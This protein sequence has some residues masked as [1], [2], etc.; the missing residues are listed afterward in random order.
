MNFK[1]KIGLS[2][3]VSLILGSSTINNA[4]EN[5]TRY[6]G[7]DRYETSLKT[8]DKV[9]SRIVVF[10]SG[11]NYA[12][13]MSAI[14]LINSFNAKLIL[15]NNKTNIESIVKDKGIEK[16]YLVGGTKMISKSVEDT[17]KNHVKNV[18]RIEGL[19]RYETNKKTLE[20]SKYKDVGVATGRNYAD[21]L[22]ASGLL[23]EKHFGLMLVDGTKEYKAPEGVTVKYT[24]GGKDTVK[25]DGG[26][27]LQGKDRYDTSINI[28]TK[29]TYKNI[30]I[31]SGE[32]FADALSSV[33]IV[34]ANKSYILL[35]E[36]RSELNKFKNKS[37]TISVV[38]GKNVLSDN[39]IND[40]I[41]TIKKTEEPSTPPSGGSGGGGIVNPGGGS[42]NK[43]EQPE[44]PEE[45][46]YDIDT[47]FK[48]DKFYNDY[49]KNINDSSIVINKDALYGRIKDGLV[50]EKNKTKEEINKILN[51]D[52]KKIYSKP[53]SARVCIVDMNRDNDL[54]GFYL[55]NLRYGEDI[56]ASNLV[57]S[58]VPEGYILCN[59]EIQIDRFFGSNRSYK[60]QDTMDIYMIPKADKIW[61]SEEEVKNTLTDN[62]NTL[63][64]KSNE[65]KKEHG[66][67]DGQFISN[68]TQYFN[69]KFVAYN[70]NMN[71]YT[72]DFDMFLADLQLKYFKSF[73]LRVNMNH[74]S[75]M[76]TEQHIF[77]I[78]V[79]PA[80]E[81]EFFMNAD[82]GSE[83]YDF[84][85]NDFTDVK[86]HNYPYQIFPS[87]Y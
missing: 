66:N 24:F 81:S 25:Q 83:Y 46:T 2:L 79:R 51:D 42:D 68:N 60:K 3:I 22:S 58:R 28:A 86:W 53:Q 62:Y 73:G 59:D 69:Y 70:K 64:D 34:N 40:M 26:E 77:T 37:E 74:Q 23:N 50:D 10:A 76:T 14:N 43:P 4:A 18:E 67:I 75:T 9:N 71:L 31:A 8:A 21:A 41:N 54:E 32:N 5:F 29:S 52:L 19:D 49:V 44:Q 38:G 82:M 12:D 16:L 35:A 55:N 78:A 15:V 36:N 30:A 47:I 27:R 39:K 17:V 85:K 57:Q 11:E 63:L 84:Y 7:K 65:Y 20:L 56:I 61:S 13:A 33:N 45:Q 6:E 80:S 1:R 72:K 87:E 48:N